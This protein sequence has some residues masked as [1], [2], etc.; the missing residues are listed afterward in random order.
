RRRLRARRRGGGPAPLAGRRARRL[1]SPLPAR[2]GHRL[3]PPFA[4]RLRRER[5]RARRR[6]ARGLAPPFAPPGGRGA[7]R[8]DHRG[9]GDGVDADVVVLTAGPWVTGFFPDL[10]VHT[11]RETVAYFRRE[12]APLPSVVQ[13]DPV[14]RG[15]ALYSLHDPVH[16]LKAGAHHAGAHVGPDEEG[17]PDP[18][19]VQRIAER[20]TR[21]DPH[22]P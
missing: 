22:P 8:G 1:D 3:R 13:V 12:G 17:A 6:A 7:G 21:T 14:T 11:T 19:L 4:P 20:V 10:P 15:H 16:G 2:G 9:V 5:P 18:A